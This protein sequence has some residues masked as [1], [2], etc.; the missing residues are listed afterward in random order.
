MVKKVC[1]NF[2]QCF[3]SSLS[4]ISMPLKRSS[5]EI[6]YTMLSDIFIFAKHFKMTILQFLKKM[7]QFF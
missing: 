1:Q 6:T 4:Y 2:G 3:A 5:W 7:L